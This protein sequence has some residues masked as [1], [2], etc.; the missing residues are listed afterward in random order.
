MFLLIIH[1]EAD[2]TVPIDV[3]KQLHYFLKQNTSVYNGAPHGLFY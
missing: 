2:E 1:G 3:S